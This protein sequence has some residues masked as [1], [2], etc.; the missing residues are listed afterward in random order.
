MKR[1]FSV[2]PIAAMAIA[3]MAGCSRPWLGA[4][5]GLTAA[6]EGVNA[7]YSEVSE[8]RRRV[9]EETRADVVSEYEE[10]LRDYAECLEEVGPR[11]ADR[12]CIDPGMP[13]DWVERW[14]D[15]RSERLEGIEVAE[16][17]LRTADSAIIAT[18]RETVRWSEARSDEPPEQ[19]NAACNTLQSA[20]VLVVEALEE[21]D[22]E[23]PDA[24]E[25]AVPYLAPVCEWA[26][27]AVLGGEEES[28]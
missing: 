14:E 20:L 21:F 18:S 27:G 19:F 22:I 16:S 10:E 17:A 8:A 23:V 26:G 2:I 1:I 6:H 7:A 25:S 13:D 28:Q 9:N 12:A 24:I 15:R 5:V 3:A 4:H 11:S